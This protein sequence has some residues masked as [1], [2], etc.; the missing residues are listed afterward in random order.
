MQRQWITTYAELIWNGKRYVTDE[1][2][3]QGY[4]HDGSVAL[5]GGAPTLESDD[6]ALYSDGTESGSAIIGTKNNTQT[7]EVDTTYLVRLSV[8]ETAGNKANNLNTQ[9]YYRKNTGSWV[10]C[11]GA[12]SNVQITATANITDASNVT[13]RITS[14][15]TYISNN[16]AFDEVDGD[17]GGVGDPNN[18]GYEV[19][20]SLTI[21]SGDVAHDDTIE[22][23][24]TDA[25]NGDADFTAYNQS[26]AA[27]TVNK[28]VA[29]DLTAVSVESASE[30]STPTI[31]QI[32]ALTPTSVESA[33]E[34]TAPAV[35]Q[36]HI[37]TVVSVESASEVTTPTLAEA[38]NLTAVSVESASEVT[39]PALTHIHVLAAVSVKSASEVTSPAIG[40]EHA[41]LATSVESASEV[42]APTLAEVGTTDDLLAISVESASEVTSPTIGQIHV[43]TA[44]S[45]ESVSETSTPTLA[46]IHVLTAVSIESVSEV[47]SPAIGQI[48]ALVSIS[49]ESLSELSFPVIG[50]KHILLATSVESASEVSIPVLTEVIPGAFQP[51]WFL[52]TH[53]LLE[54]FGMYYR[55]VPVIGFTVHLVSATTGG[56]ITTGTPVG[57]VTKDDG[58]QTAIADVT[59]IHKGNGEWAFDL[60]AA[61]MN[62]EVIGLTFTHALA[63]T[64]GFTIKPDATNVWIAN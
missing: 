14:Y 5:A 63:V 22:F 41:L 45:V 40:Q 32:H 39:T 57:Y 1:S 29:D 7:L 17:A 59:P 54:E 12:S 52:D 20:H 31:G 19:L 26:F 49:V 36:K 25:D 35:G 6:W 28:V 11:N 60:T 43:L 10:I 3:V 64:R 46:E 62:A 33:S 16:N 15:G 51:A 44:T 23:K 24:L 61:E 4:W 2:T 21:V 38:H 55:A 9:L 34:V 50:Q 58:A 42:T 8:Q 47:S 30:V 48:H 53:T 27:L 13:Q 56:D 37:L 18:S